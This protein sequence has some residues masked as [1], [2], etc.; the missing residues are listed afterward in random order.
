ML[1]CLALLQLNTLNILRIE[2]REW[3]DLVNFLTTQTQLSNLTL[4]ECSNILENLDLSKSLRPELTIHTINF[5]FLKSMSAFRFIDFLMLFVNSVKY[6][7]IIRV[8][9]NLNSHLIFEAVL[10]NFTNLEGLA[11][12]FDHF[13]T[14]EHFY[15][16]LNVNNALQ[17]LAIN[18]RVLNNPLGF[19]GIFHTYQS[20]KN[21]SISLSVITEEMKADD[22][23]Y[24]YDTLKSL[25]SFYLVLHSSS[26]LNKGFFKNITSLNIVTLTSPVDWVKLA[27]TSPN[28]KLLIISKSFNSAFLDFKSLTLSLSKLEHLEIG[29]GFSINKL[30]MNIIRHQCKN[31]KVLKL[32]TSSWKMKKTPAEVMRNMNIDGIQVVLQSVPYEDVAFHLNTFFFRSG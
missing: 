1:K 25:R 21:L 32:L 17:S 29:E 28:L 8:Q 27:R 3:Q 6:L 13:P 22:F 5:M 2:G 24:M 10:Q 15:L 9:K 18:S 26:N 20:I 16:N 4:I 7:T 23:Q 12:D 14:N 31:L 11:V 19:R 30:E